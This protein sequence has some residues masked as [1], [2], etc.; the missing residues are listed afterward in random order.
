M[1]LINQ[2]ISIEH[3]IDDMPSSVLK[4]WRE[5]KVGIFPNCE[6]CPLV[7]KMMRK[8]TK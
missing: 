3:V 4:I 7:A 6:A 8:Y 2:Q 5:Q 1:P